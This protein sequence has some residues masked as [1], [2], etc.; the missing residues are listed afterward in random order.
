MSH[1]TF[2]ESAQAHIAEQYAKIPRVSRLRGQRQIINPEILWNKHVVLL[3]GAPSHLTTTTAQWSFFNRKTALAT[4][5]TAPSLDFFFFSL[6]PDLNETLLILF[7]FWI[8]GDGIDIGSGLSGSELILLRLSCIGE[9]RHC[10]FCRVY[11]ANLHLSPDLF[12][13]FLGL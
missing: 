5:P 4:L 9:G 10:A 13:T 12:F 7:L 11:F 2:F 3:V 8:I 6:L 1:T